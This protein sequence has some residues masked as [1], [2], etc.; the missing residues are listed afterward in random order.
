[1]AVYH[2]H[3]PESYLIPVVFNTGLEKSLE[4]LIEHGKKFTY[5]QDL[6]KV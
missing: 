4:L 1:M 6:E 2:G 5:F 3:F